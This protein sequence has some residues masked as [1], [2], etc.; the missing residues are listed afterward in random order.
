MAGDIRSKISV[1]KIDDQ[2]AVKV[3]F[4][5]DKNAVIEIT[6]GQSDFVAKQNVD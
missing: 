1:R 6:E 5:D 2:T 3:V 4:S